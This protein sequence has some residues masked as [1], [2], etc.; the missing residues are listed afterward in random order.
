MEIREVHLKILCKILLLK[1]SLP[2]FKSVNTLELESSAK[3]KEDKFKN[4]LKLWHREKTEQLLHSKQFLQIL[5]QEERLD[6]K[7]L[8]ISINRLRK[9]FWILNLQ[10]LLELDPVTLWPFPS[11]KVPT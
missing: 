1:T 4:K 9:V 10:L 5:Q 7:E 11:R 2:L 6:F 3:K 8:L